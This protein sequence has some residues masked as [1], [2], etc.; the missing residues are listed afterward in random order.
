[1]AKGKEEDLQKVLQEIRETR[2]GMKELVIQ[3]EELQKEIEKRD[4]EKWISEN[5]EYQ[6]SSLGYKDSV[7]YAGGGGN[8]SDEDFSGKERKAKEGKASESQSSSIS[9]SSS[10][11]SESRVSEVTISTILPEIAASLTP[12]IPLSYQV[13]VLKPE[14]I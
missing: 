6:A 12:V 8:T 3:Q 10:S 14:N 4:K 7:D 11:L 1:M 2:K 5:P 9:S 13:T